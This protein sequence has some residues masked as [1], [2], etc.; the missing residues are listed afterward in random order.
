MLINTYV[1]NYPKTTIQGSC[2]HMFFDD[3]VLF[4]E[5]PNI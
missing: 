3:L 1:F 5:P 4:N 2:I